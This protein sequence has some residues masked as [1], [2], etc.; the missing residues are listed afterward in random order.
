MIEKNCT[1]DII[2]LIIKYVDLSRHIVILFVLLTGVLSNGFA[3]NIGHD[4]SKIS[5]EKRAIG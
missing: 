3:L 4:A 5:I 2:I 1:K